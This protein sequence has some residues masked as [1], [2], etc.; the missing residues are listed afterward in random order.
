MIYDLISNTPLYK[1]MSENL[2]EAMEFLNG[3]IENLELGKT[4][5]NGEKLFINVIATETKLRENS[6]FEYHKKYIDIHFVIE[7]EEKILISNKNTLEISKEYSDKDDYALQKGK[8]EI[9]LLMKKGRFCI[10]FPDDSHMPLIMNTEKK[11][12]KK[13]IIKVMM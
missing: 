11:T 8:E 13:G 1:G 9:E 6:F 3:N 5:I 4:I 2:D 10:V 12:I 7:G